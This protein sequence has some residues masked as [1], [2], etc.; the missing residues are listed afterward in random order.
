MIHNARHTLLRNC[1]MT[2]FVDACERGNLP[3]AQRLLRQGGVNIHA[4]NDVA[5]R[6]ACWNGQ[7]QVAKW[8]FELGGVNIH[9]ANDYA[10]QRAC[11]HGHLEVA[12]WLYGLGGVDIHANDDF[13]FTMA[14]ALHFQCCLARWLIAME[15]EWAWPADGI[16]I[17]QTWTPARDVWFRAVVGGDHH[18]CPT[19]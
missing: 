11:G 13:A 5:F 18:Q 10:F 6:R 15:P 16:R 3:E 9:A 4:Y 14:C 7:L 19:R 2:S 8:L 1:G 12:R 17:L